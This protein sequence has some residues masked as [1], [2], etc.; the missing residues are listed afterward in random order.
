LN[1]TS[2]VIVCQALIVDGVDAEVS[3][4]PWNVAVYKNE[5]LICGGSIISGKANN[6]ALKLSNNFLCFIER[7]VLSAGMKFRLKFE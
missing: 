4:F 5:V 7:I 3:D 1:V 2:F 6:D